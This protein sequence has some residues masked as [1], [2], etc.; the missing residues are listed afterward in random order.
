MTIRLVSCIRMIGIAATVLALTSCGGGGEDD[1]EDFDADATG[2]WRG[3]ITIDGSGAAGTATLLAIP[4]GRFNMIAGGVALFI[5]TG[6]TSGNSLTGTATAW[7]SSVR[8]FSNGAT[9][10]TFG[11]T[12]QVFEGN[13][14]E[15][16][17]SG[18]GQSGTFDL[19]YQRSL[20]ERPAS[21][22]LVAG[23]YIG[24]SSTVASTLAITNGEMTLNYSTGCVGNGTIQV[25]TPNRNFYTWTMTLAMCPNNG[26][27]SGLGH[28][29]TDNLLAL[30][31]SG[32]NSAFSGAFTK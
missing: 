30:T 17:Y 15:G 22:A 18:G 29:A 2:I 14:I 25:V 7:A 19:V 16:S 32:P 26:V 27:Y 4:D 1:E 9:S 23:S 20:T 13:A 11:L 12:G 6:S 5:G 24:Q 28:M 10:G 8:P 3:P 31:G 21:L